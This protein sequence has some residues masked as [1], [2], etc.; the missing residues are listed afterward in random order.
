MDAQ[1]QALAT[2]LAAALST[3]A[4]AR[5]AAESVLLASAEAAG[6]C[7]R[8]LRCSL[9]PQ[10]PDAARLL[11][12][13]Q[14]RGQIQRRWR[15][16]GRG[17][18]A[19]ERPALKAALA[20]TILRDEPHEAVATQLALACARVMRAEANKG[21]ADVLHA[22]LH[23]LRR[24]P[25]PAQALLAVLHTA[26]EWSTMRLPAQRQLAARVAVALLPE[27]EAPWAAAVDAVAT[28]GADSAPHQ[29]RLAALHT[30]VLRQLLERLADGGGAEPVRAAA[31]GDAALRGAAALHRL[32]GGA[33]W[34]RLGSA[35]G[36]LLAA[37]ARLEGFPW[38]A[39]VAVCERIVLD[40][41]ELRRAL[42]A[43]ATSAEGLARLEARQEHGSALAAHCAMLLQLRLDDVGD[44]RRSSSAERL[45]PALLTLMQRTVTQLHEWRADPEALACAELLPPLDEEGSFA[46][47]L[48]LDGDDDDDDD[49][50][51]G[52][53]DE[54][55][56]GGDGDD[57]GG[58]GGG[59]NAYGRARRLQV[60]AEN[61]LAALLDARPDEGAAALLALLP[62][63][64]SAA[65]EAL[66]AQ[67]ERDA[68]YAA[69]GLSAYHQ[70]QSALPYTAVLAA[71]TREAEAVGGAAA[72]ALA[73]AAPLQGRLCWLLASWWS[74]GSGG[75]GDDDAAAC[76]GSYAVLVGVLRGGADLAA[77]LQAAHALLCCTSGLSD[78]DLR[79]F[80][81]LAP[82]AL[83]ALA[84][85][86]A[87]ATD[88]EAC[89]WLLRL[90]AQLVTQQPA[91]W[92]AHPRELLPAA[93]ESMWARAGRD[94]R[95]LL[96][97][98]LRAVAA[99]CKRAEAGG[100]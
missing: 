29:L 80:A 61:C 55:E 57:E 97:R 59:A 66:G 69:V 43:G 100:A 67:L 20:E 6:H 51:F 34:D 24:R 15:G 68:A 77:K 12:A 82:D 90:T 44:G 31:L 74:F 11:A 98:D 9:L 1:D 71:A 42:A 70:L 27:L 84:A 28:A 7:G 50:G 45:A 86:L 22:F 3:D 81:P 23:A 21:E 30:K 78:D 58:G 10:L 65:A 17:I 83:A 48:L 85:A 32:G 39:A 5:A 73:L 25:Q 26:K 94:G 19:D 91:A 89:R 96:L 92:R 46:E 8:L 60:A 64:A 54:D 76:A 14:L 62:A 13:T 47:V 37:L 35:F 18:P 41:A 87:A 38:A 33:L 88:D 40:E 53:D 72:A 2:A 36:K 56:G 16:G 75:D 95:Q 4:T 79:T 93:L 52:G 63:S 49:D 99:I